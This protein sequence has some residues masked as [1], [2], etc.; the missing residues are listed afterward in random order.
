MAKITY[1]PPEG[2]AESV[3]WAGKTFKKGE[4]VEVDEKTEQ[5]RG[6]LMK[7][8]NNRFFEAAEPKDKQQA[9][10]IGG[11]KDANSNQEFDLIRKPAAP[12]Y[13]AGPAG[14]AEIVKPSRATQG[15]VAIETS[16]PLGDMAENPAFEE[17]YGAKPA[18][19]AKGDYEGAPEYKGPQGTEAKPRGRPPGSGKK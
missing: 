7:A 15:S 10:V 13:G 9:Q 18:D 16:R 12:V 3:T 6:M 1:N 4:A 11:F 2:E 17:T 8:Q 5:G 19:F 14:A